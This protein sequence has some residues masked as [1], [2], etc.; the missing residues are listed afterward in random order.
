MHRVP[1]VRRRR[2]DEE[3][4]VADAD[5]HDEGEQPAASDETR[6]PGD[7]GRGGRGRPARCQTRERDEQHDRLEEQIPER[8]DRVEER[9]QLAAATTSAQTSTHHATTK[10]RGRAEPQ[11]RRGERSRQR[12]PRLPAKKKPTT[13]G[14]TTASPSA[15]SSGDRARASGARGRRFESSRAHR[16]LRFARF[17]GETSFPRGP[18]LRAHGGRVI[19]PP[20]KSARDGETGRPPDRASAGDPGYHGEHA[21]AGD[22]R[23]SQYRC[24]TCPASVRAAPASLRISRRRPA[25]RSLSSTQDGLTWI[26]LE[27]PTHREAQLL[28]ARFG[29]H[30][31]DV[32]DV[33]SRRQ[34]PEGRRLHGGRERRLSLRR[35]PLPRLRRERRP[36]ERR[37]ARRLRRARLP[38][39]AARRSS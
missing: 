25:P 38:R 2:D 9:Q 4:L 19:A 37:R 14:Y 39:H 28:A 36:A 30:P 8:P 24:R 15:R 20:S 5:E 1:V 6:P 21:C 22:D 23:P 18:L 34:R 35:P 32:E 10:T 11:R 33:L 29:W 3:E 26:H 7:G 16:M 31:L 27:A 13:D 12:E 17:T